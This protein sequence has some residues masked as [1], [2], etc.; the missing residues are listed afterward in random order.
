MYD[1]KMLNIKRKMW[2]CMMQS[3]QCKVYDVNKSKCKKCTM[4][5]CTMWNVQ[6]K[7]VQCKMYDVKCTMWNVASWTVK[8]KI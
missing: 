3:V 7:T 4:L 1:E 6:C 2:N 8:C 5:N